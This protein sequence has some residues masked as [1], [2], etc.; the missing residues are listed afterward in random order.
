MKKM[1]HKPHILNKH[2]HL[3]NSEQERKNISSDERRYRQHRG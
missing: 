1:L 2:K 3:C